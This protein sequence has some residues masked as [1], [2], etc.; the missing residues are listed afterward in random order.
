MLAGAVAGVAAGLTIGRRGRGWVQAW[1]LHRMRRENGVTLTATVRE[2]TPKV[3]RNPRGGS[4]TV[5]SV[6]V[7]RRDPVA[8]EQNADQ[9]I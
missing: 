3:I 8:G 5:Y 9:F 4:V 2:A 1:R 7:S 6:R